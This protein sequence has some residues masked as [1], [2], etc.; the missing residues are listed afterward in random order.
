MNTLST[1]LIVSALTVCGSSAH[2]ATLF[3]ENFDAENG[4]I[5]QLNY[6]SFS[7]FSVS[8]GT[9]DL[10]ANGDFGISCVGGTG[11]CVDLDGSTGNAGR[12][13]SSSFVLAAVQDITL[14][15]SIS[16][17]QRGGSS[18]LVTF[19]FLFGATEF[20]DSRTLAPSDPFAAVTFT[21]S[22]ASAGSYSIFF[23]NSG[24]DNLGAILDNVAV[25]TDDSVSVVPL[26]AAAPF[27]LAGL[28][29]IGFAARRRK[30]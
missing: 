9:V 15:F 27:L 2:A 23:E 8:D 24:G 5:S 21:L 30:S 11:V 7:Q 12:M 20:T 29:A 4:G 28:G 18:D 25:T 22:G 26:P 6:S 10:I 1:A 17:N 14:S 16:G 19:G 13:T 3:S